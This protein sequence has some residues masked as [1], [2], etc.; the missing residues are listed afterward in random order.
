MSSETSETTANTGSEKGTKRG[1]SVFEEGGCY[2]FEGRGKIVFDGGMYEGDFRNGEFH[3]KGKVSYSDGSLIYNVW[4]VY[5]FDETHLIDDMK[6]TWATDAM[7]VSICIDM[8]EALRQGDILLVFNVRVS[9]LN[10]YLIS[11]V[12]IF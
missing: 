7:N 12:S 11:N 5:Y 4:L 6:K 3:G 2:T 1:R 9:F 8:R 10:N